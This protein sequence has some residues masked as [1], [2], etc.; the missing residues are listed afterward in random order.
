MYFDTSA[1]TEKLNEAQG[2]YCMVIFNVAKDPVNGIWI[3]ETNKG[4]KVIEALDGIHF[5]Q[6]GAT[7]FKRKNG[8][9]IVPRT[10]YSDKPN[11]LKIK[12]CAYKRTTHL[13]L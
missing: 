3:P 8:H 13:L 11:D 9:V 6:A 12:K 10:Y 5:F 2:K 7:L 4:S 1:F